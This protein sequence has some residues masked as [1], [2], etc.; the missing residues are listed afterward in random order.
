MPVAGPR[1]AFIPSF[2]R[3]APN[4]AGVYSLWEGSELIYYGK[5]E[6]GTATIQSCLMYHFLGH[7]GVCTRHASHYS[8]EVNRKPADLEAELLKEHEAAFNRLP[9]C[10]AHSVNG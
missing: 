1:Y 6:G 7:S 9:R 10:N 3:T 8:W 5:A 2:I 4:E